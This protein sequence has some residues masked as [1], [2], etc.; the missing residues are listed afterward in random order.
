MLENTIYIYMYSKKHFETQDV[1]TIIPEKDV[2]PEMESFCN[3]SFRLNV[4]S[5]EECVFLFKI[6]NLLNSKLSKFLKFCNYL[7]L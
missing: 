6:L 3:E 5:S 7:E 4:A 2:V 1:E